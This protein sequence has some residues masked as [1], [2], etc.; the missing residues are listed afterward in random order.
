MT[1]ATGQ[2]HYQ[3][4]WQPLAPGF[5]NVDYNNIDTIKNATSS[6]TCAV[7]LEPVQGEGGVNVPSTEYLQQVRRWC[8]EQ[9]LL[10]IFDEV[11]TGMGRLGT[12]FGYQT[13]N[14]E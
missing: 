9:G 11:Q 8:D 3:E 12:L 13:F 1:A 14:V 5:I 2:P 4:A 10:L 7:M 6:K